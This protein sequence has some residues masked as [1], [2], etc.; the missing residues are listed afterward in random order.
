MQQSFSP[1]RQCQPNFNAK[2]FI[3]PRAIVSGNVRIGALCSVWPNAVLRGDLNKITIAQGSN[4]QENVVVHVSPEYDVVIGQYVT[5]GHGAIVHGCHVGNHCLIGMHAT[6]LD[7]AR[8]GDYCIIGAHTLVTQ[9]QTIPSYS[10]ITGVPGKVV[11]TLTDQD[12]RCIEES[13]HV[14]LEL[15]AAL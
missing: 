8:I 1:H 13:A 11:R 14:Y 12:I 7:G 6:L 2:A 10:L 9:Q 5:V 4:V 15:I 3:S